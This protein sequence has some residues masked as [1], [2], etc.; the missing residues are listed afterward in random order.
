MES[1]NS[2]LEI[3]AKDVE[4]AIEL[5]VVELNVDRDKLDVTIL[6]NGDSNSE[7][8]ARVLALLPETESTGDEPRLVTIHRVL[9]EFLRHMDIDAKICLQSQET[10][11]TD[12]RPCIRINI[13]GDELAVLIG[14]RGETLSSLEYLV[15][16][17][18]S[19]KQNRWTN[20]ILDVDGYKQHRE[21]Q[22]KR[23]AQR[24]ANQVQ[25]FGRPIALEPMSA[26]ERRIVHITL[27]HNPS[28]TTN[29]TGEGNQRKVNIQPSLL[30]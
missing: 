29:S 6:D 18:V 15:R 23:L 10:S 2:R 12:N 24:M 4:E 22:L 17:I 5:A 8:L 30:R 11:P 26:Y 25:Q 27:E 28:V 3:H 13:E 19:N 14:R 1:T 20:V 9:T 16:L 7:S 21:H